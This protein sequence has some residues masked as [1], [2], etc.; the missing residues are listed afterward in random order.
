MAQAVVVVCDVCG[1]APAETVTIRVGARSY[2]KDVCGP[3]RDELLK[4]ARA[5]R[6]GR[7][8]SKPATAPVVRRTATR[9]ASSKT[10]AGGRSK[11]R[12]KGK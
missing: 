12:S 2:Q 1:K 11:A 8:R 9:K 3:H 10:K 5:P 7:P 4:G 6:R